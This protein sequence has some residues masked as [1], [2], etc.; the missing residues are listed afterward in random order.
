M[1]A[2]LSAR[3][4][5]IWCALL[6]SSLLV[7]LSEM[8]LW[9][10]ATP[11][12]KRTV[13]AN[14]VGYA[15]GTR[16]AFMASNFRGQFRNKPVKILS[17]DLDTKPRRIVLLL[18]A[19]GSMVGP[20]EE[21]KWKIALN[22][23]RDAAEKLP[24][25][26]SLALIVFAEKLVQSVGSE[27]SRQA[28]LQQL[29]QIEPGEKAL[30]KGSRRTALWDALQEGLNVLGSPQRGDVLYA[31][32]DGG[33]NASSTRPKEVE[34]ALL[35]AGVR[36]FAFLPLLPQGPPTPEETEGPNTLLSLANH[37]GGILLADPVSPPPLQISLVPRREPLSP[38]ELRTALDSLYVA[39]TSFYRLDIEL[40]QPV[41]KMRTWKLEL[42]NLPSNTKEHPELAYPRELLPCSAP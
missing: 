10:Q 18:D 13:E 7:A 29:S 12:L 42:A 31:I 19:S 35:G 32:T 34:R 2:K 6:L 33:D 9:A 39:M 15:G 26:H 36:L 17:A 37:T 16:P 21:G 30:P 24:P 1:Q 27:Q 20:S 3:I 41:D 25:Q 14:V 8:A 28:I 11:C 40:P 5:P 4:C 38:K 23:A 22:V